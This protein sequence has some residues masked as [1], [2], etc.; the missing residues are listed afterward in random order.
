MSSNPHLHYPSHVSGPAPEAVGHA[1]ILIHGRTQNPADMFAI[2]TR[3]DL[4]D[5]PLLAL[6]AADNC[7]YP[8]KFMAPLANNQPH[9]DY[10]LERLE[11][12]VQELET[13]GI[14]R[15]HIVL[16]GFS[17][18][19]CLACEYLYRHPQRWGGLLA[20]TGGL[21]GPP[22]MSWLTPNALAGTPVFLGNSEADPWVPL[23]RS[24]ETATVLR[25]MGAEVQ[26]Q[27]YSGRGHEVSDEEI[28]VGRALL[29]RAIGL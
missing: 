3:L 18:G 28:A 23:A 16:I 22:G 11:A 17:Q 21:I 7:W 14:T 9:L 10:A 4:P 27:V 2:A 20:Y 1:A 26:L 19:A 24:E 12:A 6:E 15:S 25:R 13:R 29:Q 5:L 8:D